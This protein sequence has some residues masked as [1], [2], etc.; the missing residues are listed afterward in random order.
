MGTLRDQGAWSLSE[1]LGCCNARLV[2]VRT[3]CTR[4]QT[5][6]DMLG[7]RSWPLHQHWKILLR[8]IGCS[9]DGKKKP[10][11]EMS[12]GLVHVQSHARGQPLGTSCKPQT[13]RILSWTQLS[14]K[15]CL[16]QEPARLHLWSLC[17]FK[18]RRQSDVTFCWKITCSKLSC[19]SFLGLVCH[20]RMRLGFLYFLN[21]LPL[22]TTRGQS[23][24]QAGGT[25][26]LTLRKPRM[27]SVI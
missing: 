15:Q 13:D 24:H 10:W 1:C 26:C 18:Q 27:T 2:S 9:I 7:C 21:Y 23:S 4:F 25:T 3:A 22:G 17:F 8:F 19:A 11:L 6:C 12:A 16:T 14:S 5:P 20:H